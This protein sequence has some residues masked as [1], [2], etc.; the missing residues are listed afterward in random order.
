MQRTKHNKYWTLYLVAYLNDNDKTELTLER[1]RKFSFS[2]VALHPQIGRK[3]QK[4]LKLGS[5]SITA[6]W[7][8]VMRS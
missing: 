3:C 4:Q 5:D 2:A 8:S 7:V 1:P 6:P